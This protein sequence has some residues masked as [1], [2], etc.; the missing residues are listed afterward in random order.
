MTKREQAIEVMNKTE[1]G[2][3]QLHTQRDC[4]QNDL[5]WWLCKGVYLLLWWKVRGGNGAEDG[6][7]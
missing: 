3:A 1:E 5:V 4:W 2:M 6:Q 7:Q